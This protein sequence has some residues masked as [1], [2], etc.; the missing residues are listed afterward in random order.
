METPNNK[1]RWSEKD[2]KNLIDMKKRKIK[3]E[4]I[5]CFLGRTK[6]AIQ[7]KFGF[8]NFLHKYK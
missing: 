8:I 4:Q 5:A 6:M 1:K 7:Y 3:N 2:I